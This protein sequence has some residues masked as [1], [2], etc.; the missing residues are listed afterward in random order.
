MAALYFQTSVIISM[1]I[2]PA[3]MPGADS[4]LFYRSSGAGLLERTAYRRVGSLLCGRKV[5]D[6][7]QLVG[8]LHG[9]QVHSG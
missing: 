8:L 1:L 2:G 6:A 3:P 9:P 5:R 4:P 7:G